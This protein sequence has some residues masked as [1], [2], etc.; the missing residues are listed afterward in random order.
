MP[1]AKHALD[2]PQPRILIAVH[3]AR[4]EQRGAAFSI[5]L[6]EC[7]PF[8]NL[9]QV[10]CIRIEQAVGHRVEDSEGIHVLAGT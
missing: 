1:M 4:N 6:N 8:K 3:Q 10:P 7:R 9:V 2:R 5:Q